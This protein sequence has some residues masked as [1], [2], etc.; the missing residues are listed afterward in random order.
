VN[1]E[2]VDEFLKAWQAD[3]TYFK[4]QPG[5]ISAQLHKGIGGSGTF[6]NYAVW[7]STA[8]LKKAVNN[9]NLQTRP[10]YQGILLAQSYLRIFSRKFLFQESVWNEFNYI[11]VNRKYLMHPM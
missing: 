5:L 9:T 7:E 3:A 11:I 4:S 6:I 10:D 2:D 1:P 8:Q